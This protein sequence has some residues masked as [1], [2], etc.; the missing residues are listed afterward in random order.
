MNLGSGPFFDATENG[1]ID[2]FFAAFGGELDRLVFSTFIGGAHNDYLGDT[3]D[4]RGSNHLFATSE[5]LWLGN[6]VHSGTGTLAPAVVSGGSFDPDKSTADAAG[7]DV[8]LILKL[9]GTSSQVT[10]C[11]VVSGG[12]TAPA[13]FNFNLTAPGDPPGVEY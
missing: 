13:L 10:L 5:F 1:G 11:K 4:P 6:T 8:H 7:N 12:S 2:I 9:G 3:G